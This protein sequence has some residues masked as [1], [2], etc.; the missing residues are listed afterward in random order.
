MVVETGSNISIVRPD[1]LR[2]SAFAGKVNIEPVNGNVR[3]VTG[4]TT[5]V[6]GKGKGKIRIGSTEREHEL[7]VADIENECI[8][9][10]DF[11][12]TYDCVVNVAGASLRIGLEEVQLRRVGATSR[13]QC[14]RVVLVETYTIPPRSEALLP[15]KL[16]EIGDVNEAWGSVS[17]TTKRILPNDVL[18]GRTLVDLRNSSFP[19]RVANVSDSSRTIRKGTEL[20][21]CEMVESAVTGD[22]S[23]CSA[24]SRETVRDIP[25]QV[26]DLYERSAI[27]LDNDQTVTL[28]KL[29]C[30]F[31]D[32]F[33]EGSHDL[34]RT[35]EVKHTFDTGDARPIRQPP[36]RLPLSKMEEASKLISDM[37]TQ[38][39]IEPSSGPWA[40]PVVFVKNIGTQW[41]TCVYWNENQEA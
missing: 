16:D 8:I 14:R 34:G 5:P 36:R 33:S 38:G 18:V 12:T 31:S 41:R 19:V 37:S 21:T 40:A 24:M 1:I 25:R 4:D 22:E 23:T 39:I 3:T 28:R 13:P 27:N 2:R 30:E 17:P 35:S 7:W 15:A 9:G 6:R 20:A 29:L 26:R 11:L 32:V 10:L